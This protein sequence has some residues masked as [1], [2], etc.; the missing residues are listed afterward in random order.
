MA[1]KVVEAGQVENSGETV[2]AIASVSADLYHLFLLQALPSNLLHPIVPMSH[3]SQSAHQIRGCAVVP[4]DADLYHLFLLQALPS[5]LL[6]PIVPMS[7][8]HQIRGCAVP[9]SDISI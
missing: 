2:L 3:H 6:H 1:L 4:S 8:H 5:N 9:P 7:H